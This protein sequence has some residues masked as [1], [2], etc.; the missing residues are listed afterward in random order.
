M[1]IP[2]PLLALAAAVGQRALT[3]E[4]SPPTAVRKVGA[5][6]T[7]AA[8]VGLAASAARMFS[9][10]GTTVDPL[11]PERATAL[12][13]SG[14]FALTRNPMYVGLAGVLVAHALLRG[15]AKALA[16]VAAFVA[17][18]D[19]VQIPPEE[20]AMASLFDADFEAYRRRVPRWVGPSL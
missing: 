1:R 5:A 10:S 13:T 7:A 19:R 16:P 15:S 3:S 9:A 17:V 18:I 11:R 2:P 12:V 4:A 20:S 8:S 6:V 14:P